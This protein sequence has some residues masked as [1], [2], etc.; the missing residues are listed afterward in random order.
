MNFSDLPLH[1]ELLRAI[2]EEGYTS[3]TPIQERAIPHVLEG[4]DLLGLAQTGTGK[5]AAFALPV[6]HRL[7]ERQTKPASGPRAIRALIIT[8]TRE[9]AS[10]ICESFR[11]Y[12]RH[13]GFSAEVIFG[14]VNA[15][16]QAELLR[17]GL[18]V[19]IATPGRLLDHMREGLVRFDGLEV[20]VL[21]EAD[22]MLD[23]GFLPDVKRVIAALP[24]VRQ[25]LFFSATMPDEVR[26]LAGSLLRNPAEVAVVP[27]A[28]TAEKVAQS[29]YM[30]PSTDKRRLLVSLL[31]D[32][33]LERVL[34]FTRTK[35]GANRLV[36]HLKTW[37]TDA[38]VIHGGKS[39]NARERALTGFKDGATRVLV[40]TDIAARGID[41]D[42][43]THVMNYDIP[44]LPESY[45][46]RIGRTARAGHS[47]AAIAFC[48]P[49]ERAFLRDIE[50]AIR[51]S[52]PVLPLPEMPHKTTD[53]HART[54]E[55]AAPRAPESREA[56]SPDR[57]PRQGE[58]PRQDRQ[59][60]EN[61]R[62]ENS[63]R[64]PQAASPR[65]DGERRADS[66]GPRNGPRGQN[67]GRPEARPSN[68]RGRPQGQRQERSEPRQERTADFSSV[69]S[70]PVSRGEPVVIRRLPGESL[71]GQAVARVPEKPRSSVGDSDAARPSQRDTRR[72]SQHSGRRG[73]NASR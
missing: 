45:V 6:L 4:R 55:V 51:L 69:T 29:V 43:V 54:P 72:P 38:A 44:N 59:P 56:R 46:H 20:F 33:T 48:A 61:D 50:R 63:P 3:P 23:M 52:I 37:G 15:R 70:G 67:Q 16:P 28:T 39:Q 32:R 17:R 57:G 66:N 73:P 9:L 1:P 47:G 36:E 49:E 21:D 18:D 25:S 60:R 53:Q 8:P 31:A 7:A 24:K 34:V 2:A 71:S 12:G 62:R 68:G 13:L 5:T 30:V 19:L 22:R 41:V 40:A 35:H 58:A 14:G 65:R 27:P 26:S 11:A 10:Q 64:A 42:G